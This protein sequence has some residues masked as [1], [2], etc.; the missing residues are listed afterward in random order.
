MKMAD[1]LSGVLRLYFDSAPLIYYLE[2][3][4]NYAAK[5]V[6]I[7]QRVDRGELI[8]VTSAVTLAEVLVDPLR[9]ADVKLAQDYRELLYNTD[10]ETIPVDGI[11]GERAAQLRATHNLKTPDA[12]QLAAAILSGCSAFL[13]NDRALL[14]VPDITVLILDDL[15][16]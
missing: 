12:L 3:H 9:R 10:F 8:G 5:M 4:P 6:G 13:S 1:A 11:M 15:D 16:L 14:R 7:F 2:R